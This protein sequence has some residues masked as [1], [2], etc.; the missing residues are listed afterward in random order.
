MQIKSTI[1]N[2]NSFRSILSYLD[3]ASDGIEM[4]I[5]FGKAISKVNHSS[6]THLP[7]I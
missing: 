2:L 4:F 3:S 6:P 5:K 7:N 1:G